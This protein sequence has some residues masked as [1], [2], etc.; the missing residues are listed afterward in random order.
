ASLMTQTPG[1]LDSGNNSQRTIRFAG[2]GLDDNNYRFDGVDATGIQN[3]A[4]KGTFRLQFSTEAVA[5]FRANAAVY[6]AESGG[7]QGGQV[8]VVSRS[9]TKTLHC[10][11]FE[12]L[13]N[14]RC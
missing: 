4:Q 11:F 9:R 12:N 3:Q 5:E 13:L 6:T 7:T 1:A 2:H 14:S 8:D 10:L